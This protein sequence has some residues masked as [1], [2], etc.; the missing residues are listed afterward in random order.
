MNRVDGWLLLDKPIGMTSAQALNGLKRIIQPTKGKVGH[1]GTLD[2]FASGLLLVAVGQATK[3]M[4][5]AVLQDKHYEFVIS[6]G[7][8]R[9]TEDITGKTVATTD[10]VP[11][12][13]DIS[14][15]LPKFLGAIKQKPHKYSA[16]KVNGVRAYLLARQNVNLELSERTVHAYDLKVLSHN[17]RETTFFLHCSKGFYVRSLARDL[18][19]E[20][21]TCGYVSYLRRKKIAKFSVDDAV[22]IDYIR[23]IDA[24]SN[25]DSKIKIAELVRH[26]LPIHVVLDDIQVL[27]ISVNDEIKLR[28]GQQVPAVCGVVSA[29]VAAFCGGRL[30][31]ICGL[32]SGNLKPERILQIT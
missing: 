13:Y 26:L 19:L 31:A 10:N 21:S 9:D 25:Q 12:I 32:A 16:I 23:D 30:V 20:L 18:A 28:N 11:S 14:R 29:K 5:Y 27:Q 15:A 24:G 7:E 1:A 8:N 2:P 3:L 6:W 17:N 4:E 22:T